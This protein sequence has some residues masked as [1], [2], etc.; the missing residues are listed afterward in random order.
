MGF[1]DAH[2]RSVGGGARSTDAGVHTQAVLLTGD[3]VL[4]V[5]GKCIFH[6]QHN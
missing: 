5:F 2:S 3:V 4:C 1:S 6:I